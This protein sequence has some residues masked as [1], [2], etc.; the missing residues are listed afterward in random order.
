MKGVYGIGYQIR[1]RKVFHL[2]I[3]AVILSLIMLLIPATSTLAQPQITLSPSAGSIGTRVAVT[4]NHFESFSNTQIRIF[5]GNR[6]IDSSPLIVPD[7]GIFTT[8]F[9]VPVEAKS[10]INNV[11]VRTVLGG[12]VKQSFIVQDTE[13]EIYPGDGTIATEVTITGQG[14]YA[15]GTV[16]VYYRDGATINLGGETASDIGEF[17]YVFSVPSSSSGIH[18]IMVED[19][20]DNSA[21]ANFTVIP[22]FNLGSPSGAIGD[23]VTL[24]GT[25]FGDES[26]IIIQLDS[27]VVAASITD[28]YGS[29][30]VDFNVPITESGT[31]NIRIKDDD[32]NQGRIN[33]EVVAGARLSQTMG[34]VGMSLVISGVGFQVGDMVTI[35]YDDIE[36][37]TAVPGNNGAFSAIINI[38]ASVGGNHTI[39][40][41]D[42]TSTIMQIFTM[43]SQAPPVPILLSPLDASEE[44]KEIYFDWGDVNDVSGITYT[45]QIG[46]DIDFTEIVFQEESLAQSEY[47]IPEGEEL[48]P[49]TIDAPYYWRVKSVDGASNESNWSVPM[50]LF[51]SSSFTLPDWVRYILI[52]LGIVLIVFL[53]FFLGRR[54]AY[55]QP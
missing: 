36:V 9:D 37:A 30:E 42:G 11:T 18:E 7:N 52:G 28:K 19:A 17:T 31:H 26:D 46:G 35:T 10:G 34:N 27:I 44:K 43:E 1:F 38:P 2:L 12:E 3:I 29:F 53:A 55:Y 4:G 47:S 32:G 41:T 23:S 8:T 51:V 21:A 6:E 16:T 20:L 49:T 25:G 40:C 22:D 33:F 50:S 15:G 24:S 13:I 45:I 5:F 48:E 54:T 14:F 39:T